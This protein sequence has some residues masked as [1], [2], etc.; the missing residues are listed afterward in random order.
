MGV[1]GRF[2]L[3]SQ[4]GDHLS[5]LG[6]DAV[7]CGLR[8]FGPRVLFDITV[9]RAVPQQP[10]E[11]GGVSSI[12]GGCLPRWWVVRQFLSHEGGGVPRG[13]GVPHD[14]VAIARGDLIQEMRVFWSLSQVPV[15]SDAR[16]SGPARRPRAL[17]A[18]LRPY[19]TFLSGYR[20][21]P[22]AGKQTG[23]HR[24]RQARPHRCVERESRRWPRAQPGRCQ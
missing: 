20:V 5:V 7:P 16:R 22:V 13:R 15:Q 12:V 1:G 11:G 17:M 3:A 14:T 21:L 9:D 10:S 2:D 19:M 24:G 8:I 23:R 6:G 4:P 18:G